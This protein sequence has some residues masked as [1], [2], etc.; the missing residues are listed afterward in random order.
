[1][2]RRPGPVER[3]DPTAPPNL[4]S[5]GSHDELASV[6]NM[7][8]RLSAAYPSVD[9][10]TVEATVR[11]AYDS[12][13]QARVRAYVPILVERRSRRVLSAACRTAPGQANDGRAAAAGP[14]PDAA[15]RA[16]GRERSD[17]PGSGEER[18]MTVL[19]P[20][21]RRAH[22]RPAKD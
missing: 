21:T 18:A 17:G 8:A 11:T 15:A 1:M 3:A 6:R 22:P 19:A 9:A 2:S 12:F 7:V 16:G 4:P 14:E 10:V 13:H 5:P 20:E